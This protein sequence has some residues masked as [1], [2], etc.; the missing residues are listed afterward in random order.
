MGSKKSKNQDDIIVDIKKQ[1]VIVEK[2]EV[3]QKPKKKSYY[4][5][6]GKSITSKRGV[7][8]PGKCICENDFTGGKDALDRLLKKSS[9][10]L[11]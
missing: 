4:V 6:K 11:R 9:I 7:L 8:G 3:I 10:E 1:D 5:C 2:Q